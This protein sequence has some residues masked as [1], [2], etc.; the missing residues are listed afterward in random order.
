[1]TKPETMSIM[2]KASDSSATATISIA[3]RTIPNMAMAIGLTMGRRRGSTT[4]PGKAY[5][6]SHISTFFI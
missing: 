6:A 3:K 5:N 1:M 2:L 4:P